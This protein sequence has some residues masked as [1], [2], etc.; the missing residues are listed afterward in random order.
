MAVSVPRTS[1]LWLTAMKTLCVGSNCQKILPHPTSP[2]LIAAGELLYQTL[3]QAAAVLDL[4]GRNQTHAKQVR[5]LGRVRALLSHQEIGS[6]LHP[7]I[8]GG[9]QAAHLG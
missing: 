1:G 9:S 8:T 3:C 4:D 5:D 6:G 7:I 2:D